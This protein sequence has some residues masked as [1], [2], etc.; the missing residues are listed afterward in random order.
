MDDGRID[1]A[2]RCARIML[3]MHCGVTAAL[4]KPLRDRPLAAS[5]DNS[6]V[7][8]SVAEVTTFWHLRRISE[9]G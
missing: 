9:P 8:G 6:P 3:A 1:T 4:P 2:Y 5:L 7:L